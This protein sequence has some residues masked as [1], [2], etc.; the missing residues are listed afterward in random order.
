MT[1]TQWLIALSER[2]VDGASALKIMVIF[3]ILTP[4]IV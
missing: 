3:L 2:P 1:V 4:F